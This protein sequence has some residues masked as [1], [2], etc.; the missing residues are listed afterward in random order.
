MSTEFLPEQLEDRCVKNA[1]ACS[2]TTYRAGGNIDLLLK[3]K[4]LSEI[5]LIFDYSN[6]NS[7]PVNI[8]GRG[9][10][11]LIGDKGLHGLTIYTGL[12]DDIEV[13]ENIVKAYCGALW[14]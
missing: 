13:K 10:N 6:K 2:F 4:D 9:S 7:L 3:P 8:L 12:L 14:D 1:P 11:I 5:Q